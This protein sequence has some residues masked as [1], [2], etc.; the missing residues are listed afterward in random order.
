MSETANLLGES[1]KRLTFLILI[2]SSSF[3]AGCFCLG[4]DKKGEKNKNKT[5]KM[6]GSSHCIKPH[7]IASQNSVLTETLAQTWGR[8]PAVVGTVTSMCVF[9]TYI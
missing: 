9:L 2:S 8:S 1:V 7:R 6:V 5:T 4:R 3:S